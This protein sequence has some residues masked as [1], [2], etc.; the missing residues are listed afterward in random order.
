MNWFNY[1]MIALL[2]YQVFK[3]LHRGLRD[4]SFKLVI[5]IGALIGSIAISSLLH[6][7]N[8]GDVITINASS[9]VFNFLPF[10]QS[11]KFLDTISTVLFFKNTSAIVTVLLFLILNK[12]GVF[13]YVL[14]SGLGKATDVV[15]VKKKEVKTRNRISKLV[16]T[17]MIGIMIGLIYVAVVSAPFYEI[18]IELLT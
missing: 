2:I 16:L 7:F 9:T 18:Y 8:I 14:L 4:S 13:L 6:T 17:I 5:V 15:A 11:S 3:S 1:I 12:L 10:L